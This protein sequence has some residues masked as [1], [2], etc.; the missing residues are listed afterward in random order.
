M[1]DCVPS[2]P[3][4]D[5]QAKLAPD[6]LLYIYK[7]MKYPNPPPLRKFWSVSFVAILKRVEDIGI[8]NMNENQIIDA[9]NCAFAQS[10]AVLYLSRRCMNFVDVKDIQAVFIAASRH[11]LSR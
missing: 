9:E 4:G 1:F 6:G 11:L 3:G 2:G 5:V 7:H 10:R 8:V